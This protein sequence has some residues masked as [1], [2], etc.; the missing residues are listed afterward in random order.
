MKD[1]ASWILNTAQTRG[2]VY[3]D[4]RVVDERARTVATKNGKVGH[5]SNSESLGVGIRVIA[6]G[7]WGFA[8]TQ[9]LSQGSVE[10]TAARAVDVARASARVKQ[11]ELQL[12][13]EKAYVDEWTTA[14][15]IDPFTTSI[16]DNIELLLK[17]DSELRAVE[18]ITLAEALLSFRRYEQWFYSSI[19]S[20]FHQ[21]KFISGAGYS[22]HSFAGTQIQKRA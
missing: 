19:G 9:D 12:A 6:D 3:C 21:S 18:G 14:Y 20:D 7:A 11:H 10:A 15:K 13:P 5:A 1:V 8:A 17:V 22:A 4:L 16:A 2:V